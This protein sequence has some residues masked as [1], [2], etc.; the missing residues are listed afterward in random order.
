MAM[1]VAYEVY[2]RRDEGRLMPLVRVRT[3]SSAITIA[4]RQAEMLNEQW[5]KRVVWRAY[6]FETMLDEQ[7]IDEI[8]VKPRQGDTHEFVYCAS[9]DAFIKSVIG[10]AHDGS[11]H[12]A[13]S[14]ADVGD[15]P[16]GA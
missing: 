4:N 9:F 7:Q 3:L 2:L 15:A 5:L 14:A 12:A 1:I 11:S 13:A 16:G 10:V 8:D 6:V